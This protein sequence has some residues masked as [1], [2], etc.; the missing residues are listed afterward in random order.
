MGRTDAWRFHD[1]GRRIERAVQTLRFLRAFGRV[2]A[3]SDDLGT[4]LDLA[5][6]QISYR[7]RYLTG[8]ARVPV[9]DL[10]TLDPGNPRGIAYQIAAI[11]GHLN[12]LPVLSDD[13]L[14][15]PQQ[16][17][18]RELAAILV[19]A[20]AT[21]IDDGM[22]GGLEWRLGLLSDAIARRYFLQGAEPLRA[23][24]LVLA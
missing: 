8:I 20:H 10:V 15:E 2:D 23:A 21:R 12:K 7:Q 19:T 1:M 22:L 4:L 3:T 18:A 17:Q 11:S 13:G 14:A 9:L 24:G 5:D 16:E 6:S